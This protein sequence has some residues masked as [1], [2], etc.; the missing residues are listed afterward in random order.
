MNRR[1]ALKSLAMLPAV[2]MGV[3]QAS[4]EFPPIVG[5]DETPWLVG[6]IRI[7]CNGKHEKRCIRA[8]VTDGTCEVWD[9][10]QCGLL[11]INRAGRPVR[12]TLRGKVHVEWKPGVVPADREV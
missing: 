12:V 8:N 11:R 3:V 9:S 4:K 7:Y 2:G 6:K 10:D 5:V 1:D